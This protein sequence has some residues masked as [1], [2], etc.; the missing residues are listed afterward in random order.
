MDDEAP[1]KIIM[2]LDVE[3][4]STPP[5]A[6]NTT[7]EKEGRTKTAVKTVA[8]QTLRIFG[9]N[10]D[11]VLA[12]IFGLLCAFA[13]YVF[14]R[15]QGFSAKEIST[16]ITDF[17]EL[18][19]LALGAFVTLLAKFAV[20]RGVIAERINEIAKTFFQETLRPKNDI[21]VY[22]KT[23]IGDKRTYRG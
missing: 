21:D 18:L 17:L 4:I 23:I 10:V 19:G 9:Y 5:I 16:W 2:P 22:G 11:L 7:P 15:N 8:K 20:N 12:L 1:T 6:D 13:G 14:A 3:R